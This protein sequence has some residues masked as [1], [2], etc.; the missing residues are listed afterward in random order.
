MDSPLRDMTK[1]IIEISY[2]TTVIPTEQQHY[3]VGK[4]CKSI[5]ATMKAGEMA[6]IEFYEIEQN[7]GTFVEIRGSEVIARYR[8]IE[9]GSF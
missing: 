9:D 7:D 3:I 6:G 1:E 2:P 5:N 4:S 8:K